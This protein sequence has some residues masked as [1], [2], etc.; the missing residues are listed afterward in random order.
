MA[1]AAVF[2]IPNDV[3][4]ELVCACVLPAE[5][6]L[7]TDQELRGYVYESLADYKVP[8][9]IHFLDAFP[10]VTDERARRL[11]LAR[12]VRMEEASGSGEPV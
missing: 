1:D 6:A 11:E 7:I 12:V 4:G 8:D 5:G 10:E 2:G 3:L 9:L